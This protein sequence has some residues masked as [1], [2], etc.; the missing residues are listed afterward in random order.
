MTPTTA[1]PRARRRPSRPAGEPG[2]PA[3]TVACVRPLVSP[4]AWPCLVFTLRCHGSDLPPFQRS[5]ARTGPTSTRHH[6]AVHTGNDCRRHDRDAPCPAPAVPAGGE[7]G[8]P[9]GRGHPSIHRGLRPPGSLLARAQRAPGHPASPTR[10][11][12]Q[13]SL[14][15]PCVPVNSVPPCCSSSAC[16]RVSCASCSFRALWLSV[17]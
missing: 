5:S 10:P 16:V 1:M 9:G 11:S 8:E 4:R 14:F 7:E 12:P 2:A 15:P 13:T 6:A 3:S 17:N